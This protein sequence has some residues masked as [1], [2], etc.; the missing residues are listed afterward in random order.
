MNSMEESF[1]RNGF[2][3]MVLTYKERYAYNITESVHF[4]KQTNKPSGF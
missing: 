3:S 4:Y 1:G 2:K